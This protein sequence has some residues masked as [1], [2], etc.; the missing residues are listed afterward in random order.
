M[1]GHS[2]PILWRSMLFVPAMSDRFVESATRQPA[3]AL[4]VDLEDSVAPDQKA[5]ARERLPA[6]VKRFSDAGCDVVVRVNRPWRELVRDLEVAAGPSVS[7][8]VLPKTPDAAHVRAVAEILADCEAER[9]VAPGHTRIVA[10]IEDPLALQNAPSIAAAHPRMAAM[11]VGAEDFALSMQMAV[12]ED[13]LYLPNLLCVAACRSA[14]IEPLGFIG[15]VADFADPEAFRAKVRRAC[16]LGFSGTFCVHPKQVLVANEEFAPAEADVDRARRLIEA[17]ERE[18]AQ[19]RAACTFEGRMVD[20][21]VVG[22]ARALVARHE[23]V[24]AAV[25]RRAAPAG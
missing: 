1:S 14:G 2:A 21:P 6:I 12:D 9:G 5:N 23:A 25:A 18:L 24:L 7:A 13:G 15:S 4:M 20:L 17:F 3:D 22:Q 19:G 11:I 8:V 16:R 10:M